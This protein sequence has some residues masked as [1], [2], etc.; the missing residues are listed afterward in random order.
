MH[1]VPDLLYFLPRR[2]V[3]IWLD[4]Y[5]V[6]HKPST[7]PPTIM[8]Q[9]QIIEMLVRDVHYYVPSDLFNNVTLIYCILLYAQCIPVEFIQQ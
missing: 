8:K 5:S 1:K 6:V 7:E 2:R 3:G 9:V 4:T